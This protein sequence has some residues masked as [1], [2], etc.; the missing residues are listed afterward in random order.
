MMSST[1]PRPAADEGP[2]RLMLLADA[3]RLHVQPEAHL[4]FASTPS[5]SNAA[6]REV[7]HQF[8][9]RSPQFTLSTTGFHSVA[10]LLGLLRL[11]RRYIATF[12]G[13]NYPVP[14]PNAL[15]QELE[16]EGFELEQWSLAT[17]VAAFRAGARGEPYAVT[18][19]LSGTDLGATLKDKGLFWQVPD[20]ARPGQLVGLVAALRADLTFLHAAVG[21]AEGNVLLGPPFCEG[22]HS[23]LGAR[24]GVIVTVERIVASGELR[25]FPELLPLPPGKVLAVCV[26][27]RGARPQPLH[28]T[29]PGYRD[30]SYV[31]DLD[32]YAMWRRMTTDRERFAEFWAAERA[33]RPGVALDG[34]AESTVPERVPTSPLEPTPRINQVSEGETPSAAWQSLS[35][36]ERGTLLAARAIQ[37]RVI[38]GGYDSVLA[39]IGQ[40]FA[41][42]RLAKLL[43]SRQARRL[44]ILI[45]T[46]LCD[47]DAEGADP[48]LLSQRN[49]LLAGRLSDVDHVL[50]S[51]VAGPG[52]RCLGVVGAAQVDRQGNINSSRAGGRIL[53]GSGGANDIASCAAEILVVTRAHEARL[54]AAVEFV[55]SPGW[56]VKGIVTESWE[57]GRAHADEAWHVLQWLPA[58][59]G[60][61]GPP[62]FPS[63]VTA[64]RTEDGGAAPPTASE[65][66]ALRIVA[67]RPD[68]SS[69]SPDHQRE[70]S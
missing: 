59:P 49:M 39:G 12:F 24:Q 37:R 61:H 15:Y 20:P 48:F 44:E 7:A 30:L 1:S 34:A 29:A 53:V 5:R 52:S 70:A 6:L 58:L 19:S 33:L 42:A 2:G 11:G 43:L 26:A 18:R 56:A 28:V 13:D 55:T 69:H 63:W 57:L 9:G 41:A 65:H 50:G 46:G 17:Y 68:C 25:R 54:P 22:L 3:V 4:H 40:S 64:P 62:S 8:D 21:D 66:E 36:D 16:S 32:E 45:E 31:D 60:N 10:H 51:L 27:P 14:R 47:C 35:Q 38:E 67:Q 23:A